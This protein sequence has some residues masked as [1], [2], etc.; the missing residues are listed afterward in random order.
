M[1]I[2]GV[3]III[4]SFY[5]VSC[6][7]KNKAIKRAKN[8][9][10]FIKIIELMQ[11]ELKFNYLKTRAL[12]YKISRHVENPLKNILDEIA[13]EENVSTQEAWKSKISNGNIELN[14]IDFEIIENIGNILGRYDCDEQIKLL[15][16]NKELIKLNLEQANSYIKNDVSVL[17]TTMIMAGIVLV[18]ILI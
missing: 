6:K 16:Y 7:I 8:L 4:C 9:S 18:I 15:Q 2:L 17:K 10:E 5:A 13:Q 11:S 14:E 3:F 1:K 12:I